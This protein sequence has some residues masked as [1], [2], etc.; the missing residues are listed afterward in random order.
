M[1][2]YLPPADW[3]SRSLLT[4]RKLLFTGPEG[5]TDRKLLF[6]GPEGW[7]LGGGVFMRFRG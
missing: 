5:W 2:C 3:Q 4:D 7:G 1:V 6:T